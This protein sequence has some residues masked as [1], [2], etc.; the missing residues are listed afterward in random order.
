MIENIL[1]KPIFLWLQ[2]TI[3]KEQ[4]YSQFYK[5]MNL[6]NRFLGDCG[7][8]VGRTW[9]VDLGQMDSDTKEFEINFAGPLL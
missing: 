3:V 7:S 5:F 9:G 2:G 8:T 1:S 4:K 6:K